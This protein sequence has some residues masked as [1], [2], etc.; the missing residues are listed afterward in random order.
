M[1]CRRLLTLLLA[2]AL[3]S[4]PTCAGR[5]L[6]KNSVAPP[7]YWNFLQNQALPSWVKFTRANCSPSSSCTTNAR[8]T[9]AAAATFSTFATNV[10]VFSSTLG[11]ATQEARTNSFVNSGAPV[12]QTTGSLA[13]GYYTLFCNGTGSITSL[14]GTA[15]VS[16]TGALTCNSSTFQVLDVTVTGTVILTVTGSVNWADLQN[17]PGGATSTPTTH[18]VTGASATTRAV[19]AFSPTQ[20]LQQFLANNLGGASFV[21]EFMTESVVSYT[22]IITGGGAGQFNFNIYKS[23]VE[24]GHP[25][26]SIGAIT[27]LATCG[28][29]VTTNSLVRYAASAGT[30]DFQMSANGSSCAGTATNTGAISGATSMFQAANMWITQLA[31]Y[32]YE[33]PLPTLNGKTL[34]GANLP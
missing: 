12:T 21:A 2:F 24:S 31:A 22:G 27:T 16:G 13:T 8:Y 19:D 32:P 3:S 18:I 7:L 29:A 5:I 25:Y 33:Q 9:D 1:R 34:A 26:A 17:L 23:G 20:A 14:G 15:T 10:P 6:T 28:A 4:A 11:L 30:G